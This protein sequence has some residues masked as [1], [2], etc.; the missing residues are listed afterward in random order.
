[1]ADK[2]AIDLDALAAEW[3]QA[4]AAETSA[5]PG[6][7]PAPVGEEAAAQWAA[8]VD[9]G[10]ALQAGKGGAERILN[11]DEIDSLL[12]VSLS[13]VSFFVFFGFRLFFVSVLVFFVC[14][15]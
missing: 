3:G 6:G 12:G 7:A 5:P 11:Q 14:L 8:M 9:D 13:D 1:M 15:L 2:P 10:D 4:L